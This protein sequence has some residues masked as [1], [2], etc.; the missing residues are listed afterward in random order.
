MILFGASRSIYLINDLVR[1]L[2]AKAPSSDLMGFWNLICALK[3]RD[4]RWSFLISLSSRARAL[5]GL[6]APLKLI[7]RGPHPLFLFHFHRHPFST[8]QRKTVNT[9]L[10]VCTQSVPH[11]PGGTVTCSVLCSCLPATFLGSAVIIT[12]V[13]KP[14]KGVQDFIKD[15]AASTGKCQ[16]RNACLPAT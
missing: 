3:S 7:W 9:P 13:Q 10:V 16:N 15:H 1:Q 12:F 6:A 14:A 11:V 2:Q 8:Q 4:G 5:C